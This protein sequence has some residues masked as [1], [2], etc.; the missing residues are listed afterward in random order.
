MSSGRRSRNTA[1][2]GAGPPQAIRDPVCNPN[3]GRFTRNRALPGLALDR[4]EPLG[5]LQPR[6]IA[7]FDTT[8]SESSDGGAN[9]LRIDR[10]RGL[11]SELP[12]H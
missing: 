9:R 2:Q 1:Y 8:H 3:P 4:K 12:R 5:V 6:D 11:W 7:G 10:S